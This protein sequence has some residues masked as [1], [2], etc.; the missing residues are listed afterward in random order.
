MSQKYRTYL[1]FKSRILFLLTLVKYKSPSNI[2]IY[3]H[4][5]FSHIQSSPLFVLEN[6]KITKPI[7]RESKP[8]A[9]RKKKYQSIY[10]LSRTEEL[11]KGKATKRPKKKQPKFSVKK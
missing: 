1:H 5:I 11:V 3:T 8:R 10:I 2:K 6:R 7:T 4:V 9:G